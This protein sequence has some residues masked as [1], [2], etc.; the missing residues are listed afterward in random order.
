MNYWLVKQE[1]SAYSWEQLVKDGGTFWDGVRNYQARNNLQAMKKGD[2]VLFYHS[3]VGKEI[4]GIAKVTKE[5]YPDPT[6][7]DSNWVVVDLK[8]AKAFNKSVTLE[9]IKANSKL[10]DIALI[11]QSRLSVM[12][13]KEV[14][15]KT[16]LKMGDTPYSGR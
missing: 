10:K 8:P 4:K 7:D 15:F 14:E 13:L 6:S 2:L 3:V 5:A 1:P 9:E 11:K 16:L 12:P